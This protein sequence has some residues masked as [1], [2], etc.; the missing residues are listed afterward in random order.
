MNGYIAFYNGRQC[1]V[2]AAS[3]Y[4]AQCEAVRIFNPPKS[5]RHL[6]TVMLAEKDGAPVTHSTASL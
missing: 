5:R 1:E 2:R 6:V 4:A 3:S